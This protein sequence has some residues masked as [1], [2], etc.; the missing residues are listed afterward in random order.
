MDTI[1][2]RMLKRIKRLGEPQYMYY[3]GQEMKY[4]TSQD[5]GKCKCLDTEGHC[6]CQT[7]L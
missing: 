3:C 2:Q 5:C 6:D 7:K 4:K 1:E